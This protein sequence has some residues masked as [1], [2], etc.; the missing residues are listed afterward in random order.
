MR[1]SRKSLAIFRKLGL[2]LKIHDELDLAGA[3]TVD[4]SAKPGE[5]NGACT[6]KWV[7]CGRAH[8]IEEVEELCG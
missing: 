4:R 1:L 8:M 3:D 5:R 6:E 7:D 2:V